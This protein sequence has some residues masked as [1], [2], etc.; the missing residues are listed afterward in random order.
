MVVGLV[1][2]VTLGIS[3][4][5]ANLSA[6]AINLL[7]YPGDAFNSML[8]VMNMPLI[9]S[10]II[11]GKRNLRDTDFQ[12]CYRFHY[13]ELHAHL[14]NADADSHLL[15]VRAYNGQCE[16]KLS[17]GGEGGGRLCQHLWHR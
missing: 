10:S 16:Q 14:P 11:A 15:F 7:G 8:I 5:P 2:G 3:L 12:F 17:Y 9:I 13:S 1:A 6:E 4:R